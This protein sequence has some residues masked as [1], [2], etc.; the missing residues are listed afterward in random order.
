MNLPDRYIEVQILSKN[1]KF[2]AVGILDTKDKNYSLF[3]FAPD[4]TYQYTM[5]EVKENFVLLDNSGFIIDLT[6]I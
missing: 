1:K 6:K 3:T 2:V 5:D 4:H